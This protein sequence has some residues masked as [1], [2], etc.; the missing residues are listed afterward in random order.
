MESAH[1]LFSQKF[2]VQYPTQICSF[3]FNLI[4]ITG[5][6]FNFFLNNTAND[7]RSRIRVVFEVKNYKK[8]KK[9]EDD[10][11][12]FFCETCG[13]TAISEYMITSSLEILLNAT[14]KFV[15]VRRGT[16]G[17]IEKSYYR[18]VVV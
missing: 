14:T 6:E 17:D 13:G 11:T 3:C 8:R 18:V 2:P 10:H 16:L 5:T 9:E 1:L 7:L 4:L 15:W 12:I